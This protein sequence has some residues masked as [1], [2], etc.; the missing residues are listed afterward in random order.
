MRILF[1]LEH[2]HPHIGGVEQLFLALTKSLATE[3]H[4][5][6]VVTT[7][8]DRK[9]AKH[10][11]IDGVEVFRIRTGNRF[12]FTFIGG[13]RVFQLAKGFDLIHTTS[14]NAAFPAYLASVFRGIPAIITFHEV[15]GDLW[16]KLPFLAGWQRFG[17]R[18][19][20]RLI[21]RL[22]FRKVVAVSEYTKSALIQAGV[23]KERCVRIY[24]GLDYAQ[25]PAPVLSPSETYTFTYFGRLGVSK[26]LDVLLEAAGQ[27]YREKAVFRLQLILPSRPADFLADIKRRI[28]TRGLSD[29]TIIQHE[30]PTHELWA[31]LQRSNCVVV[32]SYSEGFCFTAVEAVA[33]GVPV[34]SSGQ[35]ALKE[36]VSGKHLVM[37][38]LSPTALVE[39][40]KK[41]LENRW[42]ESP[43]K[44]FDLSEKVSRYSVLYREVLAAE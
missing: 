11:V 41:A 18:F 13:L 44:R 40:M 4:Q 24:N 34:I 31:E 29:A 22:P 39:C 37:D 27:L 5:V 28:R 9:L 32:P 2:F 25:M 38:E 30:L 42:E 14:Y 10:E 23:S 1:V 19:Y 33:L 16:K 3:G 21:L 35:G 12:G 15:W 17:Y 7:R 43:I 6:R 20:E 36:V 26:G 8:Y